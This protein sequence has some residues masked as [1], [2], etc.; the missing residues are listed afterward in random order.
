LIHDTAQHS[1]IANEIV[2]QQHIAHF[3]DG[4]ERASFNPCRI[5]ANIGGLDY[6]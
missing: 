4:V 2:G 6:N 5:C 1:A 3:A